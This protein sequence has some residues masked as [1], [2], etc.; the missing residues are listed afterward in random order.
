MLEE[1]T[2]RGRL[3]LLS[4]QNAICRS[5]RAQKKSTQMMVFEIEDE[6]VLD[7]LRSKK[8]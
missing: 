8:L 2:G 3:Y 1:S 6:K 4:L 7:R 5:I